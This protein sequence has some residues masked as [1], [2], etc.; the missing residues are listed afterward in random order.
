MVEVVLV[1]V[2]GVVGEI[3]KEGVGMRKRVRSRERG[4]E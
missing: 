3:K 1:V 2:V 4:R